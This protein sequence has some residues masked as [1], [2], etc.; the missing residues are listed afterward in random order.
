M[1]LWSITYGRDKDG[2][3]IYVTA[4]SGGIIESDYI[5]N[6]VSDED[7]QCITYNNGIF[8]AVGNRGTI[9]KSITAYDWTKVDSGITEN[10]NGVI[11]GY[12][13]FVAVGDNGTVLTSDAAGDAWTKRDLAIVPASNLNSIAYGLA[14]LAAVGD[15]GRVFSSNNGVVWFERTSG[16]NAR[17]NA[18]AFNNNTF[19]ACGESGAVITSPD[20]IVWTVRDSSTTNNLLAVSSIKD[21]VVLLGNRGTAVLSAPLGTSLTADLTVEEERIQGLQMLDNDIFYNFK[22]TNHGPDTAANVNLSQILSWFVDYVGA[23]SSQGGTP[24][25]SNEEVRINFGTIGAGESAYFTTEVKPFKKGE[26]LDTALVWS[27][28][29]DSNPA[30]NVSGQRILIYDKLADISVIKTKGPE[31]LVK[32]QPMI[33]SILV[34]NSG[35]STATGVT[36]TDLL[37]VGTT[38]VSVDSENFTYSDRLLEIRLGELQS[39][40]SKLIE[41][42]II[43]ELAGNIVNT[44]QAY[45]NEQDLNLNNNQY[46]LE[47]YVMDILCTD[48]TRVAAAEKLAVVCNTYIKSARTADSVL[49]EAEAQQAECRALRN[50]E[51]SDIG[52]WGQLNARIRVYFRTGEDINEEVYNVSTDF[53]RAANMYVPEDGNLCCNVIASR[54]EDFEV[55]ANSGGTVIFLKFILEILL[56]ALSD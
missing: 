52:I 4:G 12:G 41:I 23:W 50:S 42:K 22:V 34:S 31:Y 20:G 21:S 33:Y 51:N 2:K 28:E 35:P 18:V 11:F 38:F 9:Y 36:V 53:Y 24:Y 54:L 46:A 26:V 10:I 30:D 15:N 16:T 39:G 32:G 40:E 45:A 13:I 8:I 5:R 48:K 7:F 27:D 44:V 47:S 56:Q 1:A 29:N 19:T 14:T 55:D 25:F 49:I 17:L 37:P 3:N 6:T 43:P